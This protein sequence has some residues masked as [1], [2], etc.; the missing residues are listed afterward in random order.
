[1]G[2]LNLEDGTDSF[3]HNT[4]EELPLSAEISHDDLVMQ[5]MAWLRVVQ[6]RV[7]RFDVVGLGT[8]CANLR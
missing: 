7:I 8:L 6:F 4:G 1:L 2:F 5:A 3:F